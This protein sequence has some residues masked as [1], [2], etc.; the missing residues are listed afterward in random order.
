M[1]RNTFTRHTLGLAVLLLGL[2]TLSATADRAMAVCVQA[3]L[4][5][6]GFSPGVIDGRLGPNTSSAVKALKASAS[7]LSALPELSDSTTYDWCRTLGLRDQ[8][9]AAFWPSRI[10]SKIWL[11]AEIDTGLVRGTVSE[12]LTVVQG[13]FETRYDQAVVGDFALLA[14][15]RPDDLE[16]EAIRLRTSKGEDGSGLFPEDKMVCPEAGGLSAVG[17]RDMLLLCWGFAGPYDP[18]WQAKYNEILVYALSREYVHAVQNDLSGL[19]VQQTL[20]SG[21]Y[22]AGPRWLAAGS[23][24]VFQDEFRG[25]ETDIASVQASLS[26]EAGGLA[27]LRSAVG[28]EANENLAR[29]AARLLGERYGRARLFDYFASLRQ[30]ES[31]DSAFEET[32]GMSLLAFEAEFETLRRDP[33]AAERFAQGL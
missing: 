24:L 30:A 26:D 5:I 10:T 11:P 16:A 2:S 1:H 25:A 4:A 32:F 3:Q 17:F 14:G 12:A 13:F 23:A 6:S 29:F 15:E 27:A 28:S 7:D 33:A 8:R 9:L 19:N 20:P 18:V 31:W 22:T 21:E